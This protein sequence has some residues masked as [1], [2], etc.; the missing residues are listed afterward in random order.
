MIHPRPPSER[1]LCLEAARQA[2]VDRAD[3]YRPPVLFFTALAKRWSLTL[4]VDVTPRQVALCMIELKMQRALARPHAD[5]VVDIAGYAACL[6]EIDAFYA[7]T[8]CE[9]RS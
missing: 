2:V 3:N 1:E 6:A 9:R 5:T 7:E 8:M 4:G